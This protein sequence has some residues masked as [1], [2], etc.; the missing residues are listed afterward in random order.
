MRFG[1]LRKSLPATPH[2]E[3]KTSSLEDGRNF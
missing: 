1:I 2:T 3:G